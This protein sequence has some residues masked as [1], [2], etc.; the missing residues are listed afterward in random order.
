MPDLKVLIGG[1]NFNISCN[2]GEEN[3]AQESA[4]L[5]NHEAELLHAQLG[6]L[7]ED[8]M[9]LLSGLLLGD[10]IRALKHEQSALEEALSDTQSKVNELKSKSD[11]E[12]S[13]SDNGL[14]E[15][16]NKGSMTVPEEKVLVELQ[17]ISD[18]LDKLIKNVL[19]LKTE[20][21][22]IS[23]VVLDDPQESFL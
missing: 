20:E 11:A 9:L 8:K 23:K 16:A 21:E 10:K 4:N 3:A 5:L 13:E 17:D 1:R 18:S 22:K 14:T 19:N 12:E 2:P 7:P 15:K 6:R